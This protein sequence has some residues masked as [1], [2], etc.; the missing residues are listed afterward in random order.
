MLNSI[1]RNVASTFKR[2][3]VSAVFKIRQLNISVA[4]TTMLFS[5]VLYFL[6]GYCVNPM[7]SS[8]LFSPIQTYLGGVMFAEYL[9]VLGNV[10][11]GLGWVGLS[12]GL[13]NTN[14]VLST[15]SGA[16]NLGRNAL[17]SMNNR[18][19]TWRNM[20]VDENNPGIIRKAANLATQTSNGVKGYIVLFAIAFIRPERLVH[21]TRILPVGGWVEHMWHPVG[22]LDAL[23]QAVLPRGSEKELAG[24]LEMLPKDALYRMLEKREPKLGET[25][26]LTAMT[27]SEHKFR[28]ILD[29]IEPE[30]RLKFLTASTGK[31]DDIEPLIFKINILLDEGRHTWEII[32]ALLNKE[33]FKKILRTKNHR[34]DS[35]LVHQASAYGEMGMQNILSHFNV[36]EKKDYLLEMCPHG[37]NAVVYL[38]FGRK[39]EGAKKIFPELPKEDWKD[40][41]KTRPPGWGMSIGEKIIVKL[42]IRN[43]NAKKAILNGPYVFRARRKGKLEKLEDEFNQNLTFLAEAYDLQLPERYDGLDDAKFYE[44]MLDIGQGMYDSNCV[45]KGRFIELFDETAEDILN[46][47]P[48]SPSNAITTAYKQL[49]R[50]HHPDKNNGQDTGMSAKINAAKDFLTDKDKRKNYYYPADMK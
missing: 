4:I 22:T 28:M 45:T 30:H 21:M 44:L 33:Q 7:Y 9:P 39:L 16:Q 42:Y 23:Q 2:A 12:Y 43:E 48:F 40:I 46:L 38:F 10:L 5:C 11:Y 19:S 1:Y 50:Q 41:F 26:L 6:L 49:Q 15:A 8:Q 27:F 31:G 32:E 29:A 13:S 34:G 24:I 3:R 20:P 47:E 25:P 36:Q 18:F 35:L 37:L 17:V 14:L